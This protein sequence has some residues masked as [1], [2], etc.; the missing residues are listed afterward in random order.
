MCG[1]IKYFLKTGSKQTITHERHIHAGRQA[2]EKAFTI[3][4]F[5]Q[6]LHIA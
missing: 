1:V 3:E 5:V 6:A 4:R 2:R